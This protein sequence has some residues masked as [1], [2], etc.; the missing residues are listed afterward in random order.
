V[1]KRLFDIAV[2][3]IGLLLCLPLFLILAIAIKLESPGPVFFRQERVGRHGRVFRIHKFRSMRSDA[4]TGPQIT[5]GGDRR[6]TRVGEYIR[7]WKLDETAQLIDVLEGTMSLVGPRP[8]VPRYVAQ[9]PDAMRRTILSIRPG[10]TDLA[11]IVFRNENDI[12]AA[13]ADPE[14]AYV[15]EVLPRKLALQAQ[16]VRERSFTGD[17][18]ILARTVA[19]VVGK[20][21]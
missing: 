5:V 11:S 10:I 2:S 4:G 20:S 12:L 3:G 21:A 8:E 14:R 18:V 19:A 7:R 17:L 9:Y 6:I 1:I 13:A 15:E 16:Y